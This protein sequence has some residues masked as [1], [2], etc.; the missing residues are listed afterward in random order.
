MG[1]IN[2]TQC[3]LHHNREA[4]HSWSTY[5]RTGWLPLETGPQL[6]LSGLPAKPPLVFWWSSIIPTHGTVGVGHLLHLPALL[7]PKYNSAFYLG[8]TW[9]VSLMLRGYWPLWWQLTSSAKSKRHF[10]RSVWV[11]KTSSI[12]AI[13][14]IVSCT[15][16]PSSPSCN[17]GK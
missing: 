9:S 1:L 14:S 10:G 4:P 15:T 8:A 2:Q 12:E 16:S 6:W 3:L 7:S 11:Q 13:S 5:W 17:D